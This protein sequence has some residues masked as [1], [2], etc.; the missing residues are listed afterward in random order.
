MQRKLVWGAVIV[1]V[2]TFAVG[3]ATIVLVAGTVRER[4]QDE[5]FRQAEVTAGFLEDELGDITLDT[6]DTLVRQISEAR[7]RI[8]VVMERARVVGGHDVIEA[9]LI[10][11]NR[12][13]PLFGDQQLLTHIPA[14]G[15]RE[16]VRTEV[17]GVLMV[18]TVRRIGLD[19]GAEIVVAIGR[20]EPVLPVRFVSRA[21]LLAISVGTVTLIA[22]AV[23][24]TGATRRRL[25]GLEDAS[26]RIADGDLSAR[27]P[28]D[29]DDEIT[30]VSVAFNDMVEQLETAR[31]R[32]RAFLMAVGHDL[33]TPL[34]T[35]RGYAEALDEGAVHSAD[36][37]RVAS[38]LHAQTDRL[39]RLVEDL[40]LLARLEAREFSLRP[41][42]VDLVAHVK[43]I[44]ESYRERADGV[45]VRLSFTA[46]PVGPVIVDPD[47]LSQICGNLLDNALR[48]TPDGGSVAVR[49]ESTGG[50][51]RLS[52]AD[53]GPGIDPDDLPRVF[54]RLYVAE[55]YRPVRPEGSGLGLSIVKELVDAMEEGGVAVGS[56]LGGGTTVAV[57]LPTGR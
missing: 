20:S 9:G 10:L 7:A 21:L 19:G 24:F 35:I 48:Y 46:T 51:V 33:R 36:M 30:A 3:I 15:E 29:G 16:V 56:E 14:A 31:A 57:D 22:F 25:A 18:A 55:R 1:A 32:E 2:I 28:V 8:A 17:D 13:V 12:V 54:D 4:A 27:A 47:R 37:E 6:D 53:S 23:W 41:E 42:P 45:H 50:S 5:L 26:R 11:P 52:V 43:E 34:T 49:V 39:S 40:A 44:V 38:V